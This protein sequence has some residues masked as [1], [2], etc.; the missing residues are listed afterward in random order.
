MAER[1]DRYC[2]CRGFQW[3]SQLRGVADLARDGGSDYF[4]RTEIERVQRQGRMILAY[5]EIG[6]IENC[7]PEW[8]AV[9][10]DVKAGAVGGWPKEQYVLRFTV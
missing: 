2:A 8:K 10:E 3:C 4:T 6:A 1:K 7:R 5:F 9:P